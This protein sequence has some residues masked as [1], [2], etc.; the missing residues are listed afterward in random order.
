MGGALRFDGIDDLVD[1]GNTRSLNLARE[2]TVAAWMKLDDSSRRQAIVSK[3]AARINSWILEIHYD[4][5]RLNFYTASEG[6][7]LGSSFA[8]SEGQ[9]S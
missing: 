7:L 5:G 4:G 2:M 8:I 9:K 1:C 3:C 6:H